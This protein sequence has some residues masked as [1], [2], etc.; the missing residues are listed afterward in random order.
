MS[1]REKDMPE[2]PAEGVPQE[3]TPV[4]ADGGTEAVDELAALRREVEELRDKNLRQVAE[5][6]NLQK[7]AQ[8]ERQEALRYAES[9][10]ARELLVVLDDFERTQE[11][12]KTAT[13]VK[14]V[15]DG[16]RIVQENLLKVLRQHEIEPIDAMGKPFDPT[17][18]E[19]MMQQPSDEHAAGIVM[20]EMARGYTMH[21]RVIRP[22]RVIVSGGPANAAER[23]E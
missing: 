17:Y 23:G 13:D 7:R 14:S 22:S 1:K 10:F 8:R 21:Q 16:V 19:A 9:E 18:H 5:M 2:A 20:Q 12:V 3:E 15:A 11:S 4:V 6:Q